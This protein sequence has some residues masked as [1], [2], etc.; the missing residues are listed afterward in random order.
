MYIPDIEN[1]FG[2]KRRSIEDI[3]KSE[4]PQQEKLFLS[5]TDINGGMAEAAAEE[6]KAEAGIFVVS[7]ASEKTP[8]AAELPAPGSAGN[9]RMFLGANNV[10][11][12]FAG[13]RR[14]AAIRVATPRGLVVKHK[15]FIAAEPF[16][17]PIIY[18]IAAASGDDSVCRTEY[19]REY[20]LAAGGYIIYG[21]VYREW[22]LS[23]GTDGRP[24][25]RIAEA[26]AKATGNHGMIKV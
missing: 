10:L 13:A 14:L 8:E 26:A 25:L 3:L 22:W 1:F 6:S 23:C 17:K 21:A 12:V 24:K 7:T 16:G 19:I 4:I 20:Q 18:K 15:K 9:L 11:H 5:R 2:G